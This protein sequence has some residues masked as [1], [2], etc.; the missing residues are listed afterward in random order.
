MNVN[1]SRGYK[2]LGEGGEG[3]LNIM[4]GTCLILYNQNIY[5][6]HIQNI[7]HI[8]FTYTKRK[9]YTIHM[10]IT[11][12]I[13][14]SH[15]NNIY[16]SHIQMQNIHFTHIQYTRRYTNHIYKSQISL[17]SSSLS[18]LLPHFFHIFPHFFLIATSTDLKHQQ[19][20]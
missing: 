4:G 16:I 11:Q 2:L 1:Y 20:T 10:Y 15:V 8:L 6:S 14:N 19:T 18:S 5:I 3:Y 13:Y 9:T 12:N 7:K 17:T